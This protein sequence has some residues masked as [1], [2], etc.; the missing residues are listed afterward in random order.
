MVF[1][2]IMSSIEYCGKQIVNQLVSKFGDFKGRIYLRRIMERS[3]ENKIID[4]AIFC[5]WEG[6]INLRNTLVHNNGIS[7]INMDYVYPKCKLKMIAGN[8]TE[9]NLRLFPGLTD[10]ILEATR[11][12]LIAIK[13]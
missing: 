13:A 4:D 10:W 2:G 3:K 7:E 1:I 12:W 11:N 8:M 5:Q 9:G 6:V